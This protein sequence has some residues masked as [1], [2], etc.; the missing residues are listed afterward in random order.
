MK[1]EILVLMPWFLPAVSVMFVD[2]QRWVQT[3]V[4]WTLAQNH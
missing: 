4:F 1:S 3:A 2:L